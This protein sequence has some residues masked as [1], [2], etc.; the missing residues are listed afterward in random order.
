MPQNACLY[1]P[2]RKVSMNRTTGF[3]DL[4]QHVS[5]ATTVTMT[6]AM[7]GLYDTDIMFVLPSRHVCKI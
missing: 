6:H 5:M 4:R 3:Y 1:D 7:T 2:R